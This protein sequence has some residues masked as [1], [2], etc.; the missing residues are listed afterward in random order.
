MQKN[1]RHNRGIFMEKNELDIRADMKKIKVQADRIE[2]QARIENRILTDQ[3]V[4]KC[5]NLYVEIERL[6]RNAEQARRN[7]CVKAGIDPDTNTQFCEAGFIDNDDKTDYNDLK[8][9]KGI[10]GPKTY[11]DLFGD[12]TSF[13]TCGFRSFAEFA[14]TLRLNPNDARLRTASRSFFGENTILITTTGKSNRYSKRA[15]AG[16]NE[17]IS[18]EGGFLVPEQYAKEI[19]QIVLEK[20]LMLGKCRVFP[21]T[22]SILKLPA[23]SPGDHTSSVSG[24]TCAWAG[25]GSTISDSKASLE[26]LQLTASKLSGLTY[27]SSELNEDSPGF[28][29]FLTNLLAEAM[30]WYFDYSCI[31]YGDG[32]AKPQ[33]LINSNS[34]IEIAKESNQTA[35][36]INSANLMKMIARLHPACQNDAIWISNQTTLPQLLQLNIAVGTSGFPLPALQFVAGKDYSY[37]LFGKPLYF[38]EKVPGLGDKGDIVL[39]SP[40]NYFIGLRRNVALAISQHVRFTSDEIAYRITLRA[41]GQSA[42]SGAQIPIK[43]ASLSNIITLAERA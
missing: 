33:A 35:D 1:I 41:D 25:E 21:M 38:T 4:E 14:K 37:T 29:A 9:A 16:M 24:I 26:M 40:S 28:D 43:G 18:S 15:P 13:N 2:E 12:S 31:S 19:M 22:T 17:G 5:K 30:S 20:S 42:W 34:L 7:A 6:E 10:C 39:F 11:S 23:L 27:A 8:R 32:S 3:E 36:T